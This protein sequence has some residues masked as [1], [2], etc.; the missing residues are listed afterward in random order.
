[1]TKLRTL[2]EVEVRGAFVAAMEAVQ[3]AR[4]TVAKWNIRGRKPTVDEMAALTR[5]LKALEEAVL[6]AGRGPLTDGQAL[7]EF[8]A[9]FRSQIERLT[10]T[11]AA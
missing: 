10:E 2:S 9:Y 4:I 1:M 5:N 7:G 3:Y 8:A 6:A 11:E